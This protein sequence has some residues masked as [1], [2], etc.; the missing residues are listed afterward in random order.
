M[1]YQ[2]P[3]MVILGSITE[4]PT[5]LLLSGSTPAPAPAPTT[6]ASKA[7]ES[8]K[9]LAK[10]KEVKARVASFEAK[11]AKAHQAML[12][13]TSQAD[14]MD[15]SEEEEEECMEDWVPL[16]VRRPKRNGLPTPKV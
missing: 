3:V 5:T 12:L 16:F 8:A 11:K 13:A 15:M 2:S 10:D 14:D 7:P 6:K 1:Q 9:D 4:P